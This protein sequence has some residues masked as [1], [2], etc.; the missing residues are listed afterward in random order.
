M[1]LPDLFK[2]SVDILRMTTKL[3]VLAI[4][5]VFLGFYQQNFVKADTESV[6]SNT[7]LSFLAQQNSNLVWCLRFEYEKINQPGLEGK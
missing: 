7:A 2:S 3:K 6:D 4:L 5:V 1:P